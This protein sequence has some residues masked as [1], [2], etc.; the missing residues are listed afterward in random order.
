MKQKI[1]EQLSWYGDVPVI[2]I[3]SAD[4][5]LGLADAL[6]AGGLPVA[7][8]TFRTAAAA[9]VISVLAQK[10]PEL[11]VGAGTVLS[12]ETMQQAK[13]CGA[14]FAVAPGLNPA[15]VDKAKQIGMP[16]VPGVNNPTDIEGALA[17]GCTTLKFLPAEASG[18]IAYWNAI[19]APYKHTGV[20]FVP[21]GGVSIKNLAAYLALDVVAACG[22]T[23][24]AT[25]D[26]IAQGNW[27]QIAA[28]CREVAAVVKG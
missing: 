28:R 1:M 19:A 13:D 17:L 6:L 16:F 26:D 18:G 12:P 25:K 2:E 3:D 23:W 24:I 10:R 5:A 11:I 9:D 20:R 27:S 22:G 4:S 21:T 15:V 8:I 7:E 14:R